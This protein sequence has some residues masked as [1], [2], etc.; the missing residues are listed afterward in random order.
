MVLVEITLEKRDDVVILD[1]YILLEGA[2]RPFVEVVSTR[3]L[4]TGTSYC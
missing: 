4:E 1:T 2:N 3:L